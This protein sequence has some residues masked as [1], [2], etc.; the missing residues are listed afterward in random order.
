MSYGTVNHYPITNQ[1]TLTLDVP[2]KPTAKRG[3]AWVRVNGEW[4]IA[5]P[6]V[7]SYLEDGDYWMWMNAMPFIGIGE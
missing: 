7:N 1:I 6:Y 4:I 5:D 2:E 3:L